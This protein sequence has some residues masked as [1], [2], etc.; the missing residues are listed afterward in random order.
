MGG[1][2]ELPDDWTTTTAVISE[3]GIRCLASHLDRGKIRKPGGGIMKCSNAY[4]EIC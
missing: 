2:L 3:I 4:Q 1:K